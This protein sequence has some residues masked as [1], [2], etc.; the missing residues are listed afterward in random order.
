MS[1]DRVRVV[2]WVVLIGLGS[3]S[4]GGARAA[5][6][7]ADALARPVLA[8]DQVIDD[9][10]SY[11][12]PRIPRMPGVKD[13]DDWRRIAGRLRSEVKD[14]VIFR[15]QA[16]AWRDAPCRVEWLER[17]EGGPGYSIRKLR[18][19]AIPGLWIPALLYE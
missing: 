1:R 14:R 19:E 16:A 11:L 6:P 17:I 8:K 4:M 15:G 5:D 2:R 18:Y 9:L 7:V 3:V 12:E 10:T 13:A